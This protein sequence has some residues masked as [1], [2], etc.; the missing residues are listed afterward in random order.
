MN[1]RRIVL[2]CVV[3]ALAAAGLLAR[4]PA[5]AGAGTCR[6]QGTVALVGRG[7]G[8]T[9]VYVSGAGP[10]PTGAGLSA[11]VVRQIT[12]Q[13][14]PRWL[15]IAK[16][17]EVVFPNDDHVFHH[18]YSPGPTDPFNMHQHSGGER[19]SRVFDVAGEV[20]VRCKIHASMEMWILVLE[21]AW[22]TNADAKGRFALDVPAGTTE[23]HVWEPF[24]EPADVPVSCS[25]GAVVDIAP[26][27][28]TRGGPVFD[29]LDR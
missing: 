7:L 14:N 8:P 29:Y 18:V 19:P 15:V 28:D 6:V 25:A 21:N 1:P 16:G 24:H 11:P 4:A 13:F 2:A 20:V 9:V 3:L 22:F 5:A 27:L 17:M 26:R 10:A 12:K 23:V